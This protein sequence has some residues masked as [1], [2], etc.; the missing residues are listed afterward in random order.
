[1]ASKDLV[2]KVLY[3]N[4]IQFDNQ[5]KIGGGVNVYL[6]NLLEKLSEQKKY[7]IYFLSS[8]WKYNPFKSST[9]IRKTKNFW[10]DKIKTYEIVNSPIMAPAYVIFNSLEKYLNDQI[11]EKLFLDFIKDHG[12]FDVIHIHNIEGIS[13]NVLKIKQYFP[14]TKIILTVHNYQPICPLNQFFKFEEGKTCD[15]F[16]DGSDCINCL[17]E[18]I[19]KT[20]YSKRFHNY[21]MD[22]IPQKFSFLFNFPVKLFSKLYKSKTKKFLNLQKC[23]NPSVFKTYRQKNIEIINANADA[24]L[25]VSER[26][27]KILIDNGIDN[28]KVLVSYIGTKFADEAINK[29]VCDTTKPFT[30]AYLGYQRV[31]KGYY[32]LLDAL[33]S[34][35]E[36]ISANINVVLAVKN[37]DS[38]LANEKLSKFNKVKIYNGYTH[39]NLKDI[40]NEVNLGI[41][42]V[43]W[44]DNLPQVAIEMVAC[45]VPI[46]CSSFGGASELCKSEIFK[47]I[48]ADEKDFL[49]HLT[50][51]AQNPDKL[52][53]YWRNH[54]ELKKMLT[55]INE[56]E[57]IYE[58]IN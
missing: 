42:P 11:T 4:W 29:S 49:E 43:L 13:I 8:G 46:L 21:L 25:A 58:S 23:L 44:E 1:M 56:L 35:D 52:Q 22:F 57:H 3:Y 7:D 55:H 2:K 26:V 12:P 54:I 39:E 31:D 34:L 6:K 15:N 53:E 40:L 28:N 51:L 45:G 19:K 36:T 30:I 48:G 38:K 27:K 47:F 14:N 16:N 37:I 33:S 24:V 9:Y 18:N 50:T 10:G 5:K 17:N 32:F 41:V 20:E